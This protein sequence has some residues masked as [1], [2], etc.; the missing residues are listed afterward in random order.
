M[1]FR[2]ALVALAAAVSGASAGAQPDKVQ[3]QSKAPTNAA[4]PV[5]LASAEDARRPTPTAPD[6][7]AEPARH[8]APRVTTCRC[9]DAQSTEQQP[10]Q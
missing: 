2:V 3:P 6:R 7:S 1:N 5:V 8:P 9:G 4:V 10:D